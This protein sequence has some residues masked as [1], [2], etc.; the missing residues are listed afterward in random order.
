MPQPRLRWIASILT[1]V[2]AVV[3]VGLTV[4]K[5]MWVHDNIHKGLQRH[6]AAITAALNE[7]G[8]R[9]TEA[10][11]VD[12][13]PGVVQAVALEVDGKQIRLLEFDL[14]KEAQ[15]A[16]VKHVH[17]H[18]STKILGAERPAEDEGGIVIIDF[19]DHP[20]KEQLLDAFHKGG[21]SK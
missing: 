9:V 1:V 6:A 10:H 3:V 15:A 14:S 5:R 11:V 8:A 20:R 17:E 2:L 19:E 4:G 21:S 16:E 13:V 18:H 12:G 7:K